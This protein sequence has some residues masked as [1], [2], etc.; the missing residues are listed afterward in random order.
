MRSGGWESGYLLLSC[1][2]CAPQKLFWR[3]TNSS[4]GQNACARHYVD[5]A[6]ERGRKRKK[7]RSSREV[8]TESKV[9]LRSIN[10]N[11][12]G[13]ETKRLT[14]TV[15]T[16]HVYVRACMWTRFLCVQFQANISMVIAFNVTLLLLFSH[17]KHIRRY[18]WNHTPYT[19]IFKDVDWAP[20]NGN[21]KR[22]CDSGAEKN[23]R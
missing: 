1:V 2:L 12:Y 8:T 15:N 19:S 6:R 22:M 18:T 23:R 13:C 9:K 21:K 16:E 7:E 11:N 10:K 17:F 14:W 3:N 4:T 20:P 5:T